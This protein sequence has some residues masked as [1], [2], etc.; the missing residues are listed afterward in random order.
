M[1]TLK[2]NMKVKIKSK[3]KIALM[4]R[5]KAEEKIFKRYKVQRQSKNNKQTKIQ[6]DQ[7]LKITLKILKTHHLKT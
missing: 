4:L 3:V 6:T 5:N 7:T 2:R 1:I